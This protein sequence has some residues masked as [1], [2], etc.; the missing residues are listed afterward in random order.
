MRCK[1]D[2]RSRH[3]RCARW[4]STGDDARRLRGFQFLSA[5][6]LLLVVNLDEADVGDDRGRGVAR[7]ASTALLA[8][9]R[10]G[11]GRRVRED[12]ARDR[13]ARS[14]PTPQAFMA[15]LGLHAVGARSRDSRGVRPARLHLV[16][17]GRR[18]RMPRVVDSAR[19]AGA[20]SGGRDPLRHPARVHPRRGRA[21]RSRCSR[22]A[23][24]PPAAITASCGSKAR[25]TSSPTATSSTS[26]TPR[27]RCAAS[28]RV[29]TILVCEAQVPFVQGG[30]EFHVRELVAPAPRARVRH[31]ARQ[32]ALQVVSEA[33]DPRARRGVAAA[34]SQREQRPADRP[35]DRARSS[36]PTSCGIRTRSRGSIHQHR[37][38]YELAG[39]PFSDFAHTE[40]DVALRERLIALDTA[41]LGE[42]RRRVRQLGQHRGARRRATT[43]STPTP[44]YHPPR[45]AAR[46]RARP[47]AAT[48]CCRWAGS[49]RSSAWTSRFAR[50]AHAPAGLSLVVAGTGTQRAAL[51]ALAASLGLA[52]ARAV[53]GRGRRRRAHRPV[54][55][56]ARRSSFRRS[57]R[58]TATSRSRRFSRTS[59]SSRR[60]TRAARTSS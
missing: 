42:C 18:G 10:R 14:R 30:A 60:P 27:D 23:R 48:T 8:E 41:M 39:T 20:G 24:S 3:A 40:D 17:H 59:R 52:D 38:A 46:L 58:T 55:R 33:G 34:R 5:K 56:R 16:L 35:R 53:P 50:M 26:A 4:G 31:R 45:L 47:V 21:V 15:D 51:E 19:H 2:A 1:A 28:D 32:R 54:R 49:S 7:S 9:T 11:G 43:A 6:P 44:L 37:A 12:R 57:T 36:R 13:A 25:S 29:S 22:A